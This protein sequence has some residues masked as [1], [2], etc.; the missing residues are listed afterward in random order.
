[1]STAGENVDLN[2]NLNL[3]LAPLHLMSQICSE[4]RPVAR[5]LFASSTFVSAPV[6]IFVFLA[7]SFLLFFKLR[8][9]RTSLYFIHV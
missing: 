1:M 7:F 8:D 5:N 4:S 2:L 9:L 3:S 6:S